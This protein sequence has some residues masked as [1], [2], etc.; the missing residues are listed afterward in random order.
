MF[1]NKGELGKLQYIRRKEYQLAKQA[2]KP[3][4][5]SSIIF[6]ILGKHSF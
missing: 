1:I 6:Q 3:T 4:K 5:T 2:S